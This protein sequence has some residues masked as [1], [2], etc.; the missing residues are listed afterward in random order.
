MAPRIPLYTSRQPLPR[1]DPVLE[2]PNLE[3]LRALDNVGKALQQIGHEGFVQV[4]EYQDKLYAQAVESEYWSAVNS[5]TRSESQRLSSLKEAGNQPDE[6][7]AGIPVYRSYRKHYE[8]WAAEER[9]K[10]ESTFTTDEARRRFDIW[11]EGRHTQAIAEL[12][13]DARLRINQLARDT[14]GEAIDLAI[15]KG[16]RAGASASANTALYTGAI[17][18]TERDNLLD[19]AYQNIAK[20]E[21][22]L[23]AQSLGLD[24]GIAWLADSANMSYLGYDGTQKALTL[25]Q[26]EEL[27]TSFSAALKERR[28]REISGHEETIVQTIRK[29]GVSVGD[30]EAARAYVLKSNLDPAGEHGKDRW[31]SII[32]GMIDQRA[33]E[34]TG[35]GMADPEYQEFSKNLWKLRLMQRPANELISY[36]EAASS[37]LS[38]E[39]YSSAIRNATDKPLYDQDLEQA[40]TLIEDWAKLRNSK[41]K[42]KPLVPPALLD[43]YKREIADIIMGRKFTWDPA[44]K[45]WSISPQGALGPAEIEKLVKN[46]IGVWTKE[47]FAMNFSLLRSGLTTPADY[48]PAGTRKNLEEGRYDFMDP[49]ASPEL[50]NALR[51]MAT[52]EIKE[53]ARLLGVAPEKIDVQVREPSSDNP[54]PE[55]IYSMTNAAGGA[56]YFKVVRDPASGKLSYL[57]SDIGTRG[58]TGWT[59]VTP[60]PEAPP[61]AGTR[62][63]GLVSAGA[64]PSA[65]ADDVLAY[66]QKVAQIREA[67]ENLRN[68]LAQGYLSSFSLEDR[69]LLDRL[70]QG[71]PETFG[72]QSTSE[73][74]ALWERAKAAR[75]AAGRR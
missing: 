72:E 43:R 24:G 52:S 49:E 33:K 46:S 6:D 54:R 60:R 53:L 44:G 34:K 41:D 67:Q 32:Q 18:E 21:K 25:D 28:A 13:S 73:L 63:Q 57:R 11:R 9:D 12:D 38:A 69:Q 48:D 65:A 15:Q 42:D 36:V 70:L 35:Q 14:A 40:S 27:L 71:R 30:L 19:A 56:S 1:V 47:S 66:Q 26:Q 29:K 68:Y 50:T 16:D 20:R 2:T 45:T 23:Q 3:A 10:L 39:Q 75:R 8:N 58:A 51:G 5:W 17:T 4:K 62:P 37:Q 7:E 64:A 59:A 31:L 74:F 22:L 55:P 61:P